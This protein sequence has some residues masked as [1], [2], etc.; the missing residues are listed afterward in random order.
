MKLYITRHGQ[1]KWNT[2]KRIQGWQ[3]SDLTEVGRKNAKKLGE[4]L[5]EIPFDAVYC[6]SSGR[7][8]QTAEIII[9]NRIIPVYYTDD[10][11]EINMGSWEGQQ[12]DELMKS[13]PSFNAFW[14]QPHT[15]Q[16][17]HGG[18]SYEQVKER[19]IRFI[20]ELKKQPYEN[21]LLV[22]H[23]VTKKTI[24][25][26]YRSKALEHFWDP[27]FM[28]DTSLSIIEI[29]GDQVKIIVEGDITHLSEKNHV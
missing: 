7:T 29:M 5:K 23:A 12:R 25:N 21:V 2:Q 15:F 11:K 10:L 9:G 13:D 1:T 16:P 17:T 22:T 4:R 27:P 28:H 24:L 3:N 14:D 26:Y 8:K 6:S 20:D 19:V 18:E